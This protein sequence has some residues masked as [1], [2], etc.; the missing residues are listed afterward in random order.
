MAAETEPVRRPGINSILKETKQ[1]EEQME[2][3][4]KWFQSNDSETTKKRVGDA[5]ELSSKFHTLV[6]D[7]YEYGWGESFH[8]CP[9]FRGRS[10]EECMADCEKYVGEKLKAGPGKKLAVRNSACS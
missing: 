1:V 9:L 10:F 2:Q 5:T 7:F 6:T 3:Y 4:S 8:F